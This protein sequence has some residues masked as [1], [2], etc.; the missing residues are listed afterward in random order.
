MHYH[1]TPI[2]PRNFLHD[3]AGRSFCVSHSDPRDA[4]TCH[5]I[6]QSV[7]LDNGAYNRWRTGRPTD[8]PDYYR[9]CERWLEYPTTWAVIPDVIDGDEADNDRLICEWPFGER[10]APVWHLHEPIQRLC[11]LAAG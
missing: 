5:Q 3:L 8:W 7:M 2:T 9:W 1:G 6:G 10:G 4:E 11:E